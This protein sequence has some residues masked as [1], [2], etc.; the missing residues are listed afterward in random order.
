MN[1][2]ASLVA[3]APLAPAGVER[4]PRRERPLWLLLVTEPKALLAALLLAAILLAALLAPWVS[5]HDPLEQNIQQSLLPPAWMLG[6]N[7]EWPLGT[8]RLGRD[9]LSRTIYGA[10]ISLAVGATAVTIALLVGVALGMLAG[11]FGGLTE[12]VIMRLADI[13]LAIP[14][15][16]LAFALAAAIGPSLTTVIVVLG[17]TRWV[18][19]ARISRGEVLSLK[20]RDFVQAAV[21][22]GATHRRIMVRHILP[23]LLSP[24]LVLATVELSLVIIAESALS[25]LGMGVQ[26]PT[27]TWGGMLAIG[28]DYLATAWWLSTFPGLALMLTVLT[29]NVLGDWLRDTLDPRLKQR[30]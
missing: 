30:R 29:V 19:Y 20:E 2:E 25:F 26:P 17:G 8:D 5:P 21:S 28:R 6:G 16:L 22:L 23:N 9:I 3:R 4:G 27:P 13:Q 1:D 12:D 24:I 7:A 11:Y 15:I 18:S 14:Y 10:R